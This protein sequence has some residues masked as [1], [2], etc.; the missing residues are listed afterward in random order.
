MASNLAANSVNRKSIGR[1]GASSADRTYS[2]AN[3]G[4]PIETN[5][6]LR[7]SMALEAVDGAAWKLTSGSLKSWTASLKEE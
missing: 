1:V 5:A 2:S 4:R 3:A 6:E 7:L